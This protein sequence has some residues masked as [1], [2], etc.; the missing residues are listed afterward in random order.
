MGRFTLSPFLRFPVSLPSAP[1]ANARRGN[2]DIERSQVLQGRRMISRAVLCRDGIK[3]N[4]SKEIRLGGTQQLLA[5]K[6]R[7][8]HC[9]LSLSSMR[10]S[11][12]SLVLAAG[13]TLPKATRSS[14]GN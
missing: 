4:N 2:G 1:R 13:F 14:E 6:P 9:T 8:I 5:R 3:S 11:V 7:H 12:P 10:F